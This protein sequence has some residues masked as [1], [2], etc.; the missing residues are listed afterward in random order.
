MRD[1][2]YAK[3]KALAILKNLSIFRES[4]QGAPT[5]SSESFEG[6][7]KKIGFRNSS[8]GVLNLFYRPAQ[9]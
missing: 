7:K 8:E 1:H 9:W 6:A 2:E 3:S 5:C 4:S